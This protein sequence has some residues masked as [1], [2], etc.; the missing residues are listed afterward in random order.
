MPL[1]ILLMC[2]IG[3]HE[4]RR[5]EQSRVRTRPAGAVTVPSAMHGGHRSLDSGGG[6]AGPERGVWRVRARYAHATTRARELTYR[7]RRGPHTRRHKGRKEAIERRSVNFI[8]LHSS[9]K[10]ALAARSVAPTTTR[11]S[12][13]ETRPAWAYV[14]SEHV[15]HNMRRTDD[16]A[17]T[18]DFSR[19]TA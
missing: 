9:W 3:T 12:G 14:A 8:I 6:G 11:C 2:M 7:A 18:Q 13:A 5:S 19:A 17:S 15:Q 4:P 1:L 16:V 10:S